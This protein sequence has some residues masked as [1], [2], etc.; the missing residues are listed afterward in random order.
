MTYNPNLH[1]PIQIRIGAM[2]RLTV[3]ER[4]SRVLLVLIV[5]LLCFGAGIRYERHRAAAALVPRVRFHTAETR[6]VFKL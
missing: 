6:E 2:P 4:M 3:W 1:P 5:A